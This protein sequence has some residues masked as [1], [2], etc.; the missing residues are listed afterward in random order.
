MFG[1]Q[2]RGWLA[3]ELGG[4]SGRL[5]IAVPNAKVP[6]H[7]LENVRR[8]VR[9]TEVIIQAFR[10]DLAPPAGVSRRCH[11]DNLNVSSPFTFSNA[12]G[13]INTIHRSEEHTFE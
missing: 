8:T 1:R 11:R 13:R 9:L 12:T 10:H 2:F 6:L 4:C 3:I 7:A 5:V